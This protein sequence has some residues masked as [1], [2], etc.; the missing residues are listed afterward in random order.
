V[1]QRRKELEEHAAL[2]AR[3]EAIKAREAA[4]ARAHEARRKDVAMKRELLLQHN[5]KQV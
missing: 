1:S 2:R 3:Q 5:M 4:R